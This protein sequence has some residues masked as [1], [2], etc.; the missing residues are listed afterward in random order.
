MTDNTSKWQA[1]T[2]CGFALFLAS[3]T[4]TL[5]GSLPLSELTKL[6]VSQILWCWSVPQIFSLSL[7]FLAVLFARCLRRK[8]VAL[9]A[10]VFV[11]SVSVVGYVTLFAMGNGMM[12]DSHLVTVVAILFGVGNG[13]FSILWTYCLSSFDERGVMKAVLAASAI[14]PLVVFLMRM[15][16]VPVLLEGIVATCLSTVLLVMCVARKVTTQTDGNR[17]QEVLQTGA[18]RY[19]EAFRALRGSLLCVGAIGFVVAITRTL[20]LSRSA[21]SDLVG[22]VALVGVSVATILLAVVWFVLKHPFSLSAF[23]RVVFPL[24]ATI[25]L[26]LP[27]SDARWVTAVSALV[28]LVFSVVSSLIVLSGIQIAR[29]TNT[30]PLLMFGILAFGMYL[31]L[32][33]GTVVGAIQYADTGTTSVALVALLSVYVL[34]MGI[35][36]LQNKRLDGESDIAH[37]TGDASTG[38]PA[39]D[40]VSITPRCTQLAQQ[41]DLSVREVDVLVLLARGRDVPYI[42]R[43]LFISENTVRYHSKNIYRKLVVHNKQELL[44]LLE[45][46]IDD[47]S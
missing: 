25:L 38:E 14:F 2:L 4:L 18:P 44:T 7:T 33:I 24:I 46:E 43:N 26:V 30:D 45:K 6:G 3:N 47:D 9:G 10:S 34:S 1:M 42:A 28:Y 16:V 21:S 13:G 27:F 22:T 15:L 20:A 36:A 17:S 12:P 19:R 8:P 40:I 31:P 5:W 23:Y 35:I 11:G 37:D 39:V 41:Y 29:R 32:S